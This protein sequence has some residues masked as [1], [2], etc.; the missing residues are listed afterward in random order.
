MSL[1][2]DLQGQGSDLVLLH[3]WGQHGAIWPDLVGHLAHRQ[4]VSALDLPGHGHS[5]ALHSGDLADWVQALLDAAP[6]QAVWIGWSL[7]G[8][9]ALA[10][11][12]QAPDRVR[13]LVL[14]TAT[15]R[16]IQA[17]DWPHG[18]E[19]QVLDQFC[20]QL[21]S[22]PQATLDRF[23]TLG[24]RGGTAATACLRTLHQRL[25][26]RPAPDPDALAAGL[27]LLRVTDLRQRLG[28]LACP[29]L[30]LFGERDPLV[31]ARVA[32]SLPNL[33]PGARCA[34]IQGAAHVPFLSHGE[35]LHTLLDRF[36]AQWS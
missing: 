12:L 25:A 10:A 7:G 16:F 26:A 31:S 19:P 4:R 20:Q 5:P 30:W 35:S 14:V 13:G 6:R 8:S 17:P 27:E 34:V 18:V 29:S 11:A 36:L 3:G 33:C 2:R 23:L 32:D 9:L 28:A 24:V 22:D 1:Y 21:R 15:P